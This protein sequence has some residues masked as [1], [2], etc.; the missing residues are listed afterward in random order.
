ME[1]PD[2]Q[3]PHPL[4]SF[5]P[6]A[7]L[8][9]L[10]VVILVW[11]H[12]DALN[13]ASQLALII[14]SC[15][16]VAISII[17]Y[18]VPWSKFE[19][20]FQQTV[21]DATISILILLMIGVMSSTWMISGVVPTLIYY[22]VQ[23]MTPMFFLPCA[24]IISS[25]ISVM[26]GTSWTTI[27]TIGIA[28]LGV[29]N[30]I[31]IPPALSAGAIIS[32][33][34][35]GD[36]MSPMSDTTVLASS[37]AKADLFSHIRYMMY[38]TVPSITISLLL[39]LF[40]GL[41]FNGEA[42]ETGRYLEGLGDTFNISLWTMVVPLLTGLMIYK[43]V[44]SIITLILSSITACLCALLL[45][46]EVVAGIGGSSSVTAEGL[47]KGIMKVC[48]ST[49]QV[50]TGFAEINELVSTRGMAGMLNT[51][52]LIICAMCFGACMV[53]SGMLSSLTSILLRHL[54]HTTSLV[55]STVTSGVALNMIMGDQFLSIIM[56]SSIFR[57][58]YK[59]R[60]YRPELLSRS[61]EDS[62]TVTSVLVPWTACGMTQSTV[63]GIPTIV[64]LP[65]CFFNLISPFMSCAIVALGIGPTKAIQE[66]ET[67]EAKT[68]LQ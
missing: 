64:Y 1:R 24:C 15:V 61:T 58:E 25:L 16:C 14:A 38:T 9:L 23:F 67:V 11:M 59:K 4:V 17:H 63:L 27:A 2:N 40:I 7:I 57:E 65:F 12:D 8:I 18:R 51:I 49:T 29:G 36:K 26:T 56:N 10:I 21:G 20:S 34:Y 37:M 66:T 60:G 54:R 30:A 3:R 41:Q 52:W 39:Y 46:P 42:L 62:S 55:A 33:A 5:I 45:Q 19:K 43:K 13:G 47:M 50:D 48:Y 28:L 35:F 31:G 44:P 68:D 6:L 53:A 22:G 32:G